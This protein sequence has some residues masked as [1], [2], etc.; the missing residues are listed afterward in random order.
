MRAVGMYG[1]IDKYDFVMAVAKTITMMG[2]S[3][4]V[5][6]ATADS[7]YKYIVRSRLCYWF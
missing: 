1:Y 4:L 3:V 2:K 6:D 7:K 5:V